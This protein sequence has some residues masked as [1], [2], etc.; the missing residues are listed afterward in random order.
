MYTR[1]TLIHQ[2]E[3]S[4]M[5]NRESLLDKKVSIRRMGKCLGGGL[6]VAIVAGLLR[7]RRDIKR[8]IEIHRM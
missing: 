2:E 8:L 4:I 6:F 5:R 7:H 3:E 1:S